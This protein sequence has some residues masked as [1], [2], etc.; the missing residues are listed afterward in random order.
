VKNG[1]CESFFIFGEDNRPFKTVL[2]SI[3]SHELIEDLS[4]DLPTSEEPM[5]SS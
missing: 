1:N 4:E 5:N 3:F 2:E